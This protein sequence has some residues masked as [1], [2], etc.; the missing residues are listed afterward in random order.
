[1]Y[2][3]PSAERDSTC[4][5]RGNKTSDEPAQQA[6]HI[7]ILGL[8][9]LGKRHRE[10]DPIIVDGEATARVHPCEGG[11]EQRVERREASG[12]LWPHGAVSSEESLVLQPRASTHATR[13]LATGID[14]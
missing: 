7:H 3:P 9:L 1:M 5:S 10:L 2:L 14:T 6:T 12:L 11:H 13:R 4:R 8:A